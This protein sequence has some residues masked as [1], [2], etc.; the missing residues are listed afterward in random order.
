MWEYIKHRL[1]LVYIYL[2]RVEF[3]ATRIQPLT[4]PF[5]TLRIETKKGYWMTFGFHMEQITYM[6][7]RF[8]KHAE[9]SRWYFVLT[10]SVDPEGPE[11]LRKYNDITLC[12]SCRKIF[13]TNEEFITRLLMDSFLDYIENRMTDGDV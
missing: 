13:K 5:K 2:A 7:L 12:V 6:L 4:P 9:K 10:L 8:N 3:F 1:I 11:R